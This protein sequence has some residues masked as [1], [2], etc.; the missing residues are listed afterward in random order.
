MTIQVTG[1]NVDAGDAYQ[2]YATEKIRSVI[3]KYIGRDVDSHIR[4]EK[5]HGI[6]KTSCSV[7]LASGL[8]LEAHGDGGDAYASADEAVHR[9]ETRVRRY[10]GRLKDHSTDHS[11][12]RRKGNVD[13]RDYVVNVAEDDHADVAEAHPLIIAET[14]RNIGELSVSEA[15]MQLDVSEAQFMIFKNAAHGGLNVVYRRPD[16]NIGWVDAE[17]DGR[18]L[19]NG[20]MHGTM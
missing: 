7:K 14:A 11:G 17:P 16:G 13:A 6:F 1:K 5:E 15:V 10:K 2:T 18:G 20:A 3:Q 8:L 4:L 12:L 19:S 9:L